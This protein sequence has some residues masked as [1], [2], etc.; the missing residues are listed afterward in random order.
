MLLL[1]DRMQRLKGGSTVDR[2]EEMQRGDYDRYRA[3]WN[4]RGGGCH[5]DGC[6][7]GVKKCR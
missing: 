5:G 6:D 3:G 2:G 4:R 1:L 7:G